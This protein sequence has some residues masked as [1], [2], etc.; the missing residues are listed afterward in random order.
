MSYSE[1]THPKHTI[2]ATPMCEMTR[3]N[4][5]CST[6]KGLSQKLDTIQKRH[7]CHGYPHWMLQ[8]AQ[9]KVSNIPRNRLL[10]PKKSDVDKMGILHNGHEN[11]PVTFSTTYSLQFRQISDIVKNHL[12]VLHSDPA[13][14]T[15]LNDGVRYVSKK[16]PTLP[17]L[18][19]SSLMVTSSEYKPTM[20]CNY[21]DVS[22]TFM[23]WLQ[24]IGL[25]LSNT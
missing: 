10:E 15:V 24:N 8:S 21:I 23:S 5:N 20:C 7:R 1:Q 4:R 13:F 11:S 6:S 19:Y 9:N 17:N 16:A 12:S 18:V 25:I 22:R 3:T 14:S 2:K